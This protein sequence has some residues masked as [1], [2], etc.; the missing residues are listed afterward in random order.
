MRH[1]LLKYALEMS[2]LHL[3][4]DPL[5]PDLSIDDPRFWP[6][7]CKPFLKLIDRDHNPWLRPAPPRKKP[8]EIDIVS[9]VAAAELAREYHDSNPSA[10]LRADFQ[11]RKCAG[12]T[13][14]NRAISGAAGSQFY[15]QLAARLVDFSL[16]LDT[17]M[18]THRDVCSLLRATSHSHLALATYLPRP[19]RQR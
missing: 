10:T 5:P 16:D 8:T 9:V 14:W 13:A 15:V 3:L 6:W 4:P 18:T 1:D 12:Q 7:N 17:W 19:P 2:Q 11:I